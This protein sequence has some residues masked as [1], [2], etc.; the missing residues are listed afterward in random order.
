MNVGNKKHIRKGEVGEVWVVCGGMGSMVNCSTVG[1]L[2]LA[3]YV[4]YLL[5][6]SKKPCRTRTRRYGIVRT[7]LQLTAVSVRETMMNKPALTTATDLTL[8][9]EQELT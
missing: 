9:R 1:E 4:N 5:I 6:D 7:Y 3:D 8:T 2:V